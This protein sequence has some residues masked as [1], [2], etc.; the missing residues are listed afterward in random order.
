MAGRRRPFD[1]SG[2]LVPR[3][4]TALFVFF[5]LAALSVAVFRPTRMSHPLA[6]PSS[7]PAWIETEYG[8][9]ATEEEYLPG[10]VDCELGWFTAERAALEAQAIAARTYL[11]HYLDRHGLDAVVPIGPH[12]QCWRRPRLDRS[13]AA[14]SATSGAV[15]RLDGRLIYANYASGASRLDS[16]CR[17]PSPRAFGY[18]YAT[19]D[20]LRRAW[21]RG[22]R[23]TGHAWTEILVT[24]N[25][26]RRPPR[27]TP[28]AGDDEKNRGALG[29]YASVCLAETE[30]L[31]TVALLR[32]FYGPDV[33]VWTGKTRLR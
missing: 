7:L 10:V 29:Q 6:G 17:P 23:F 2:L 26:D 28:Q 22:E 15:L 32:H 30:D 18:R 33:E 5:A 21:D 19:W 1:L 31:D 12:F 9:M 13:R 8:L 25:R 24:H 11:A 14:V 4:A 16:R 27:R 20:E 3:K